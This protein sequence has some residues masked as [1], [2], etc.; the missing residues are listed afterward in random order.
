MASRAVQSS[1][2]QVKPL[3]STNNRE[4]RGR[5]MALYKAWYRQAPYIVLEYN[6]PRTVEQCRAKLREKFE[7]NRHL[8]DIRVIDALVI[9][10]QMELKETVH[11]WKQKHHLM[12]HYFKET[13]DTKPKDFM[14]KFL[15]GQ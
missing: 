7:E 13:V 12:S 14:S 5:V 15:S 4:A 9:K 8:K 10:G 11:I 1:V 2:R 3:I 6:I